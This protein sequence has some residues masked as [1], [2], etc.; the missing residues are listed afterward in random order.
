[1]GNALTYAKFNLFAH[2]TLLYT[3]ADN[4]EEPVNKMNAEF[5]SLSSWLNLNKLKLNIEKTKYI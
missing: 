3:A 5:L 4:L 1:M 2:D